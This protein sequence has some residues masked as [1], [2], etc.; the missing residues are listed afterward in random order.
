MAETREAPMRWLLLAG[1]LKASPLGHE[2][3][4]S[5]LDLPL[6]PTETALE[7]WLRLIAGVSRV[8]PIGEVI[9]AHGGESF[10]P[11]AP[12]PGADMHLRLRADARS[13]RGPAGIARDVLADAEPDALV[14]VAES[15]RCLTTG[16]EAMVREHIESGV[17]VTLS[18]NADG[19]PAGLYIFRRRCLD[20]VPLEGFMDIKEQWLRRMQEAGAKVRVH[21]LAGWGA[22]PLRTRTQFLEAAMVANGVSPAGRLR[23]FS[24]FDPVGATPDA[25]FAVV[26][27]DV[28]V[29]AGAALVDSVVGRRAEIGA[30]SIVVRSIIA[31]G[32]RVQPGSEVVDAVVSG[33]GVLSASGAGR[34]SEN[35]AV[36]R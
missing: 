34:T 16:A 4:C 12:A 13:V 18:A 19:A 31:P 6:T 23:E 5:I 29:G 27:E 17:D 3:G 24:Y 20:T 25:G 22:L 14:A 30:G 36:R 26:P 2:L 15:K 32:A 33:G 7:R 9:V 1:G 8:A 21:R 10:R 35:N 28:A 11:N